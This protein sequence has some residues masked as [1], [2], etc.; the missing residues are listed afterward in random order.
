MTLSPL[1]T[2]DQLASYL[3]QPLATN[4]PS[5]TLMLE[6][7]SGMV[8][9][10]LEQDLSFLAGDVVTLDPI[11]GGFVFLPQMPVAQVS[12]VEYLDTSQTPAVWTTAD[13]SLYTV[14]TRLGIIA[15]LPD[16][17]VIWPSIPNSWRV[18]YDHGYDTIPDGLVGVCLGVAAR[19][20]STPAGAESER[21][22]GYQVKYAMQADG[23][24]PLEMVVLDRYRL[25]RVG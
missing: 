3:Q 11:N 25:G 15:A 7:A 20:Y 22:G 10:E 16:T 19:I 1:A 6:I 21:I 24:S 14:S 12:L 17:D 2:V 9:D 8:R 4:D 5:A 18:T 23:F 13:P